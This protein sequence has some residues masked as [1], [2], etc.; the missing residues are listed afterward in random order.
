MPMLTAVTLLLCLGA[1]LVGGVFFAFSTFVMKALA[2]LP[3]GQGVAAMQRIN[4]VVLQPLFLGAFVGTALLAAAGVV[5]AALDWGAPTS[6]LLLAAGG[7]Y[8]AGSFL[9]TVAFNVPR[10]ER[11]AGLDP[12]S[13]QTAEAW[14]VYLREW[15]RWN[16]VRTVASIASAACCAWALAV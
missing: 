1:G 11:L 7:L 4:V 5:L 6:V 2:Q 14:R 9:V 12:A 3:A 8:L 16:H 13:P 10:N 15:T